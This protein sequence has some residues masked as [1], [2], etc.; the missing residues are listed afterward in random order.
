MFTPHEL[1]GLGP[2]SLTMLAAAGIHNRAALERLGACRT[3]GV[4]QRKSAPARLVFADF[5]AP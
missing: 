3:W 4:E 2:K 5:A 1:P